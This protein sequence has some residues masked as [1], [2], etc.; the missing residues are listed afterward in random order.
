M[1]STRYEI[2]LSAS[3]PC[4]D[5]AGGLW[6][7]DETFYERVTVGFCFNFFVFFAEYHDIVTI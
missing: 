3:L 5:R 4:N 6:S 2:A 7:E 1:V